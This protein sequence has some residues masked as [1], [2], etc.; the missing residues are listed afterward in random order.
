MSQS[1]LISHYY[2]VPVVN[3]SVLNSFAIVEFVSEH[4][5]K[6]C[7]TK[8]IFLPIAH[9]QQSVFDCIYCS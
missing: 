3:V 5:C 4:F 2:T 7:A 6:L 8:F 9:R 1:V